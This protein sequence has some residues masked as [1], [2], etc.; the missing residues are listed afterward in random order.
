MI[1]ESE[2]AFDAVEM[3][4]EETPVIPVIIRNGGFYVSHDG[5]FVFINPEPVAA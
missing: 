4:A 5:F 1:H 3:Y 2:A